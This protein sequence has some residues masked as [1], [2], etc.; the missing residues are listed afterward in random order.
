MVLRRASGRLDRW[1]SNS[2]LRD[3]RIQFVDG[4]GMT[5]NP[6][7][8]TITICRNHP[9]LNT[10]E[11]LLPRLVHEMT[12]ADDVYVNGLRMWGSEHGDAIMPRAL[13]VDLSVR[14]ERN[15]LIEELCIV[16][17]LQQQGLHP[18]M[19]IEIDGQRMTA[20]DVYEAYGENP[21]GF[22]ARLNGYLNDPNVRIARW[23]DEA[24]SYPDYYGR[25][26]DEAQGDHGGSP[27]PRSDVGADPRVGPQGEGTAY[28]GWRDWFVRRSPV[29]VPATQ[30]PDGS[31]PGPRVEPEPPPP[32]G[33]GI[34]LPR[35]QALPPYVAEAGTHPIPTRVEF[36][37]PATN[38]VNSAMDLTA[39]QP[40]PFGFAPG[41]TERTSANLIFA[42]NPSALG[43]VLGFASYNSRTRSWSISYT[44]DVSLN[45]RMV[46]AANGSVRQVRSSS[47]ISYPMWTEG[48]VSLSLVLGADGAPGSPPQGVRLSGGSRAARPSDWANNVRY[49]VNRTNQRGV[50]AEPGVH[51]VQN[52][53]AA[54]GQAIVVDGE[55][56]E[57]N[58]TWKGNQVAGVSDTAQPKAVLEVTFTRPKAD[59]SGDETITVLL[60]NYRD[61]PRRSTEREVVSPGWIKYKDATGD[62]YLGKIS[63]NEDGCALIR[64]PMADVPGGEVLYVL[65]VDGM[66]GHGDGNH[67]KTIAIRAITEAFAQG[68]TP[69][70]AI[71]AALL[72]L[73]LDGINPTSRA[74]TVFQEALAR[75]KNVHDALAEA[76]TADPTGFNGAIDDNAGV[77]LTL[78][79][80][81][82]TNTNGMAL[83]TYTLGDARTMVFGPQGEIY[84]TRDNSVVM[85]WWENGTIDTETKARTHPQS[86]IVSGPLMRSGGE[87]EIREGGVNVANRV[88]GGFEALPNGGDLPPG[89]WVVSASD[90]LWDK[91][92]GADIYNMIKNCRT[93]AEARDILYRAAMA[94]MPNLP[95]NLNIVVTRVG[96]APT[97]AAEAGTV[98][99]HIVEVNPDPRPKVASADVGATPRGRPE[100]VGADPEGAGLRVGQGQ[101]QGPAPTGAEPPPPP[102]P[103][104]LGGSR[105]LVSTLTY[106]LPDERVEYGNIGRL[107]PKPR[108]RAAPATC[109]LSAN[110][111]SVGNWTN[112]H[113]VVVQANGQNAAIIYYNTNERAWFVM[114]PTHHLVMVGG[115]EVPTGTSGA[116]VRLT[117]VGET[118]QLT[119]AGTVH[120]F[121]STLPPGL[122][123]AAHVPGF[124][125]SVEAMTGLRPGE[126]TE[127]IDPRTLKVDRSLLTDQGET[128][129]M[130]TTADQRA[131]IQSGQDPF[132]IAYN[133]VDRS[134]T[135]MTLAGRGSQQ[136]VAERIGMRP[137]GYWSW[138]GATPI[139][140]SDGGALW[141]VYL[142]TGFAY[143]TRGAAV[144]RSAPLGRFYL[145]VR[146]SQ[147]NDVQM[148]LMAVYAEARRQ[149]INFGFKMPTDPNDF[150]RAD[151]CVVYFENGNEEWMWRQLVALVEQNPTWFREDGRIPQF[152]SR[153]LNA[154]GRPIPNLG[155]G[156]DPSGPAS[157]GGLIA[158][159]SEDAIGVLTR[160]ADS[161]QIITRQMYY[162]EVAYQLARRGIDV[163][164]TG[165]MANG[166][167]VNGQ[168]VFPF[169]FMHTAL[170]DPSI[171]VVIEAARRAV[172]LPGQ[173]PPPPDEL[174]APPPPPRGSR[175]LPQGTPLSRC[176]TQLQAGDE[177]TQLAGLEAFGRLSA[178]DRT[179]VAL[180]V[181]ALVATATNPPHVR[182]AAIRALTSLPEGQRAVY[183]PTVRYRVLIGE[184][185]LQVAARAFYEALT[186][187]E[188]ALCAGDLVNFLRSNNPDVRIWVLDLLNTLSPEART[189]HAENVRPYLQDTNVDV[190]ARARTF[191]GIVEPV[192]PPTRV[193]PP[194][195]ASTSHPLASEMEQIV[196]GL[197]SRDRARQL[198][199]IARLTGQMEG[200]PEGDRTRVFNAMLDRAWDVDDEVRSAAIT[201]LSRHFDS[202]PETSRGRALGAFMAA[203]QES[204]DQVCMPAAAFLTHHFAL[205]DAG[206]QE[207]ITMTFLTVLA[208]GRTTQLRMNA[209]QFFRENIL[210][211]PENLLGRVESTLNSRRDAETSP[212]VLDDI[213]VALGALVQR[214]A[215][216]ATAGHLGEPAIARAVAR[217]APPRPDLSPLP[218]RVQPQRGEGEGV[219]PPPSADVVAS[220][221]APRVPA[222]FTTSVADSGNSAAYVLGAE[223]GP[224]AGSGVGAAYHE[225][226]LAP[227]EL[228]DSH[229]ASGEVRIALGGGEA[230]GGRASIVHREGQVVVRVNGHNLTVFESVSLSTAQ[231]GSDLIEIGNR[232][233]WCGF[234]PG[235]TRLRILE[236]ATSDR[237]GDYLPPRTVGPRNTTA[238]PDVPFYS[239][240]PTPRPVT[241]Q[242]ML[243]FSGDGIYGGDTHLTSVDG[244][245]VV[246]NS[247]LASIG[248]GYTVVPSERIM[249]GALYSAIRDGTIEFD[250]EQGAW[251]LTTKQVRNQPYTT[252]SGEGG[253]GTTNPAPCQAVRVNG[254]DLVAGERTL[255]FRPDGQPAHIEIVGND[256]SVRN[257]YVG[258]VPPQRESGGRHVFTPPP[259]QVGATPRG[260]PG[261]AQ[262]PAPTSFWLHDSRTGAVMYRSVEVRG[263]P[264]AFR[265]H[266]YNDGYRTPDPLRRFAE[267][268]NLDY[269]AATDTWFLTANG[270]PPE[271]VYVN[272]QRIA[273]GARVR[274]MGP[275][276]PPGTIRCGDQTLS[277]GDVVVGERP[278]VADHAAMPPVGG[279]PPTAGVRPAD[280]LGA[281]LGAP[282][283]P[284]EEPPGPPDLPPRPRVGSIGGE[285]PRR[286]A[287]G[288]TIQTSSGTT[289]QVNFGEGGTAHALKARDET[290]VIIRHDATTDTWRVNFPSQGNVGTVVRVNG[291]QLQAGRHV[292]IFEGDNPSCEIK[293]G[294][295]TYT[296]R[297]TYA[298][299][300]VRPPPVEITARAP[301]FSF[302]AFDLNYRGQNLTI[303]GTSGR[304]V[305]ASDGSLVAVA[306]DYSAAAFEI[307]Y[308]P[309]SGAWMIR[310][311]VR[312]AD[313]QVGGNRIPGDTSYMIYGEDV[314]ALPILIDGYPLTFEPVYATGPRIEGDVGVIPRGRPE[315]VGARRAVPL[316]RG[317]RVPSRGHTHGQLTVTNNQ[318]S[319]AESVNLTGYTSFTI[320]QGGDVHGPYTG[321]GYPQTIANV[322]GNVDEGA[323]MIQNTLDRSLW[324]RNPDAPD[325]W[326][327]VAAGQTHV[328]A[329]SGEG[330]SGQEAFGEIG[331][332]YKNLE[333]RFAPRVGAPVAAPTQYPTRVILRTPYG[334]L[335]LPIYEDQQSVYLNVRP[336][337]SLSLSYEATFHSVGELVWNEG[338]WTFVGYEG[339][340]ITVEGALDERG[341]NYTLEPGT[342]R[343]RVNG[344]DLT[345]D[346]TFDDDWHM[347]LD[348]AEDGDGAVAPPAIREVVVGP[349]PTGPLVGVGSA[350]VH[351]LVPYGYNYVGSRA[352][353][354]CVALPEL[355]SANV[356]D[357]EVAFVFVRSAHF[358]CPYVYHI[359]EITSVTV[360]GRALGLRET[361]DLS[362]PGGNPDF[363]EIAGVAYWFGY[364]TDGTPSL[365]LAQPRAG[366]TGFE[367]PQTLVHP[368]D[369]VRPGRGAPI[370]GFPASPS[371]AAPGR[372]PAYAL[373]TGEDNFVGQGGSVNASRLSLPE[374]NWTGAR[375]N[376]VEVVLSV[377]RPY[378]GHDSDGS[379]TVR[380]NGREV[381]PGEKLALSR[382]GQEPNLVEVGGVAYW[383]GYNGTASDATP[384]L[385]VAVARAAGGY[386]PP[387]TVVHPHPTRAAL[388][389]TPSEG[390]YVLPPGP[391]IRAGRGGAIDLVEVIDPAIGPDAITFHNFEGECWFDAE[392][393]VVKGIQFARPSESAVAGDVQFRPANDYISSGAHDR[394]GLPARDE[395][396]V[397]VTIGNLDNGGQVYWFGY[398]AAGEP[399]LELAVLGSGKSWSRTY[400]PPRQVVFPTGQ[401]RAY[402]EA[403]AHLARVR[404]GENFKNMT[405][406]ELSALSASERT[407]LAD[408]LVSLLREPTL[409]SYT[410]DNILEALVSMISSLPETRRG[411]YVAA[412]ASYLDQPEYTEIVLHALHR[413]VE[414]LP[415][416][417][418]TPYARRMVSYLTA[419]DQSIQMAAIRALGNIIPE[420]P[421]FDRAG[422]ARQLVPFARDGSNAASHLREMMPYLPVGERSGIVASL[423]PIDAVASW[424]VRDLSD[425]VDHLPLDARLPYA[426]ALITFVEAQL[427]PT[428]MARFNP[429][430]RAPDM[431]E[432]IAALGRL[433]GVLR[434]SDRNPVIDCLHGLAQSG[435]AEA[436]RALNVNRFSLPQQMQVNPTFQTLIG[437][438]IT[439]SQIRSDDPLAPMDPDL[440]R[441]PESAYP[442]V[443]RLDTLISP[444]PGERGGGEGASPLRPG[445]GAST[446]GGGRPTLGGG[447]VGAPLAAPSF[448]APPTLVGQVHRPAPTG[449]TQPPTLG[450]PPRLG[451]TSGVPTYTTAYARLGRL[452]FVPPSGR[453][454]EMVMTPAMMARSGAPGIPRGYRI[455]GPDGGSV[456]EQAGLHVV[457]T[458]NDAGN[459]PMTQIYFDAEGGCWMVNVIGDGVSVD[460]RAQAR[461]N[462]VPVTSG[463]AN[464]QVGDQRFEF[465][466][467]NA[468][469]ATVGAQ[470]AVPLP[471]VPV[472]AQTFPPPPPL[473][474]PASVGLRPP[475][476]SPVGAQGLAPSA[477]PVPGMPVVGADPSVRPGPTHGLTPTREAPLGG[478]TPRG[479]ASPI[480]APIVGHPAGIYVVPRSPVGAPLGAPINLPLSGNQII[481]SNAQIPEL[482]NARLVLTYDQGLKIWYMEGTN[483]P[484]GLVRAGDNDLYANETD[485][486]RTVNDAP[487]VLTVGGRDYELGDLGT[488]PTTPG[489]GGGTLGSSGLGSGGLG[490]RPILGG[491]PT[492]GGRLGLGSGTLGSRPPASL[493]PSAPPALSA[494]EGPPPLPDVPPPPPVGAQFIAPTGP[495]PPRISAND[496]SWNTRPLN[497]ASMV[498]RVSPVDYS[499]SRHASQRRGGIAGLFARDSRPDDVAQYYT[500]QGV[501][502]LTPQAA[503]RL[504]GHHVV[505]V[506]DQST[507]IVQE[508]AGPCLFIAVANSMTMAARRQ[509]LQ[510]DQATLTRLTQQA[511]DAFRA[512]VRAHPELHHQVGDPNNPF[513]S[514]DEVAQ[515]FNQ[516]FAQNG[517]NLRLGHQS[518]RAAPYRIVAGN[519]TTAATYGRYN[520]LGLPQNLEA[521]YRAGDVFAT[522]SFY[523]EFLG[524]A[525]NH[526]MS[527]MDVNLANNDVTLYD[528]ASGLVYN[529]QIP[530][531]YQLAS[532]QSAGRMDV[533]YW[534]FT[535][536]AG[537]PVVL[538]EA[539]HRMD[540]HIP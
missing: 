401:S 445:L 76:R 30:A 160:L 132:Y 72:A 310:P 172:P 476:P 409:E 252:Y 513:A 509:G 505:G 203:A 434:V 190:A 167:G 70:E 526:A 66:G 504:T 169:L 357:D 414:Y 392:R 14:A 98:G 33:G 189:A 20:Q 464:I 415:V 170:N 342:T 386:E 28:P 17:E 212:Q 511:Y 472:G 222:D 371:V 92:D 258:E 500:E 473:P 105:T 329:R 439:V 507:Y 104:G 197:S 97:L 113:Q 323:W 375:A 337:E 94:D 346:S 111:R 540:G 246:L 118:V 158:A 430:R 454:P 494:V 34:V 491:R 399:I 402:R 408:N 304:F 286:R 224:G 422:F 183:S 184:D 391:P 259:G 492:L 238:R 245:R 93:A 46:N 12:H 425:F 340:S 403:M 334:D 150:G 461:G 481:I 296:L 388:I 75:G 124:R 78:A 249:P 85:S 313:V 475:V 377:P 11:K 263:D 193:E 173:P 381:G 373:E 344:D 407:S 285:P 260:R 449:L 301:R 165:F 451:A 516:V 138:G 435:N 370:V 250:P 343:I 523:G 123:D 77:C 218:E 423:Y 36:I 121:T 240:S 400:N 3:V 490:G 125:R 503:R 353:R 216:L 428:D 273:A 322:F 60:D 214:R 201:F 300:G 63:Y 367:S 410:R 83:S 84:R 515:M 309:E 79:Q 298:E 187:E 155:F 140:F 135:Q 420:L 477:Y 270:L 181:A 319:P 283:V 397:L 41:T 146:G 40:V 278:V 281:P 419:T 19:D 326:V 117:G 320:G 122:A 5:Y 316:P 299:E 18:G 517:I 348:G 25:L 437:E 333:L 115:R 134:A 390:V 538:T 180:D 23:G 116:G 466:S 312:G 110:G 86:N 242:R 196:S 448:P 232:A 404:G 262:G 412:L 378:L 51:V 406:G 529:Y 387:Q 43:E 156:M 225:V 369:V 502:P 365:E 336:D 315:P 236:V 144:T 292:A 287:T 314:D 62:W 199:A 67:A 335:S 103:R 519:Q 282:R 137:A 143:A 271:G 327:E 215:S 44:G 48:G 192:E 317:P 174:G 248:D 341:Y 355:A 349:F 478:L 141:M 24:V 200:L 136:E 416:G 73:Q 358:K 468:Q 489:F 255:L 396:P 328:F 429:L 307:Y 91:F 266:W 182:A 175:P 126:A 441:E 61:P 87:V 69:P 101:A 74:A 56:G 424:N 350:P 54:A 465:I 58:A 230:H 131:A 239:T 106:G 237:N 330:G 219:R 96:D 536:A 345:F 440:P 455:A 88:A 234:R 277:F 256:G 179:S 418:R 6:A 497:P 55:H 9:D 233:Y 417:E 229:A 293:I 469:G 257:V 16:A 331:V 306:A 223:T 303:E 22:L 537:A 486:L 274:L 338:Q 534:E 426:E 280:D 520:Q 194:A 453:A 463:R 217:A 186:P 275:G 279:E 524:A 228:Q 452:S 483:L 411:T 482:G 112:T 272:G 64:V 496:P 145:S 210:N 459:I 508:S 119:I 359:G 443:I 366:G 82:P 251:F 528:Q 421:V 152:A 205:A 163:S 325:D 493:V 393:G 499:I 288:Y 460:G 446:L 488:R 130:T 90:G 276:D 198:A 442:P 479:V 531:L 389:G 291:R 31:V 188:L 431:S 510:I 161:G 521:D 525:D 178:T 168:T 374:L 395:L 470:R 89:A 427:N 38:T 405:I 444:L 383:F 8:R 501:R 133:N 268:I 176:V 29:E 221:P 332:D 364:R 209:S 321:E 324:I 226:S 253:P 539:L 81:T 495:R 71:R 37:D 204:T 220:P 195:A 295:V 487:T 480:G 532:E 384:H 522:T 185:E 311:L 356:P 162:D 535:D 153:V 100:P 456:L 35:P 2:N 154:E 52:E 376:E 447:L 261:Q 498:T 379:A 471:E 485:V 142:P 47:H 474:P 360:N 151:A 109:S 50:R 107:V 372:P 49:L 7:N 159:A 191:L 149:G 284:P 202:V 27:L 129:E 148:A 128:G 368:S 467:L 361:A 21:D 207:T 347:N 290:R 42:S 351:N 506:V 533:V 385:E 394:N 527:V 211:I 213:S 297:P 102:V 436:I 305:L 512:E 53:D 206:E 352:T 302:A 99:L 241:A 363:I 171:P 308:I 208:S 243:S 108:N 177:A 4:D 433:L 289:K 32:G 26:Y 518:T 450:R 15:A 380:V 57:F 514:S 254:R 95:D 10:P 269:E 264:P 457:V 1:F 432:H 13:F 354:G 438:S 530:Q 318:G 413:A 80:L 265:N 68:D 231:E 244:N 39:D 114:R 157:Y 65:S 120:T 164:N 339:S 127:A 235:D 139:S 484:D 458:Q 227:P 382:P 462:V 267:E 45:P 166:D 362:M 398:N 294:D 59:G 247:H 147:A